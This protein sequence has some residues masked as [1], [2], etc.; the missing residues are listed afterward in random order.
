MHSALPF[1]STETT[2]ELLLLNEQS[3]F[4]FPISP[5]SVKV[6][7]IYIS[8]FS[9]LS[10]RLITEI[11]QEA[12]T[13]LPSKAAQVIVTFPSFFGFNTPSLVISHISASLVDHA[14]VL[15]AALEGSNTGLSFFCSDILTV[16]SFNEMIVILG[17]II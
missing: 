17:P 13:P 12:V 7:P 9:L 4:A 14:T 10:W 3:T 2:L 5:S 16:S 15:Y 1:L 11:T 6:W 8:K